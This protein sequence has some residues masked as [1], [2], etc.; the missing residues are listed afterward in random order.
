MQTRIKVPKDRTPNN[1]VLVE[2]VQKAT[3]RVF[4]NIFDRTPKLANYNIQPN[5]KK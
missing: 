5:R 1:Q 2:I 3:A 4:K